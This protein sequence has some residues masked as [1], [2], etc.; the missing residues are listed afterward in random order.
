MVDV[1]R[2][3]DTLARTPHGVQ[4]RE[5][6]LPDKKAGHLVMIQKVAQSFIQLVDL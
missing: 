3:D 4:S 5:K 1:D 6:G 2:D